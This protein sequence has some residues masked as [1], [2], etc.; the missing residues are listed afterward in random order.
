MLEGYGNS[1]CQPRQRHKPRRI[2]VIFLYAPDI[3]PEEAT[4][5][6]SFY[7]VYFTNSINH[8]TVNTWKPS[9]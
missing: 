1:T 5:I 6:S 2:I 3:A 9:Q 7:C 4:Y 8:D